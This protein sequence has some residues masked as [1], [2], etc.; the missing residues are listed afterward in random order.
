MRKLRLNVETIDVASFHP[1]GPSEDDQLFQRT[2]DCTWDCMV[3]G[4]IDS[5]W[6]SEYASCDCT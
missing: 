2:L 4:G 5:C 3:T 1:A 6:C